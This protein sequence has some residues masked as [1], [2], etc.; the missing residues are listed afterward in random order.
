MGFGQVG[1]D[2]GSIPSGGDFGVFGTSGGSSGIPRNIPAG[3]WGDSGDGNGVVGQSGNGV[4]VGGGSAGGIGV[5][6]R[7]D[8]G[9]GVE[10]RSNSGTALHAVAAAGGLAAVFDGDAVHNGN[11]TV[12]GVAALNIVNVSSVLTVNTVV[13]GS[14]SSNA[15]LFRID[16]PVDPAN[17]YL[18]HSS[19]ESPDMK[20]VYDGVSVLDERGEAVVELPAW[21]EALNQDFRYQLTAIGAP[22]PNL[23]IAQEIHGNRFRIAGGSP[24][25]KVSWQVTGVRHDPYADA[26]RV[27]V[28][29]EKPAAERGYYLHPELYGQPRELSIEWARNPGLMRRRWDEEHYEPHPAL[30]QPGVAG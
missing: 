6:G 19:V 2:T 17:K 4:G 10:A 26:H 29:E 30:A 7:A 3:V 24:R 21:F 27:Q 14:F 25:M 11:L 8:G 23:Y 18:C 13:A 16:H 28:E 15:K 9:V 20:N 5:S 1:S 22:G 12:A